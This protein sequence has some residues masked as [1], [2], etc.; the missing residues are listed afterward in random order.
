MGA[1]LFGTDGVRGKADI[2][3]MTAEFALRL[4]TAA[5]QLVCNKERRVAIG[6]DT[7][8]SGEML[9]AAMIAGFTSAGIDVICLGVLPTPA[10]TTLTPDLKV[11]M[12]VMITASH[13]PWHDNGIKLIA[14]DGSKFSDKV[15]SELEALIANGEFALSPEK[16]GRVSSEEML[17][18]KYIVQAMSAV[19][20]G[21]PLKGLRVVL[22]CANGVF[23]E[24]MP[25]V[26]M[27][28]GAGVI[29]IGNKPDGWNINR[30]CGSQHV[31]KMVEAVCGAHAQ[32]GIAV[33]GDGDRIII[34]DEKG[35][36]LDGDQVIAFLGQYLKGKSRLKGNA[37]VATI[38]SNP[39]LDRFLKSQGVDCVRS[40]VGERYVIEEMKRHGANVGGE[41]SGHM[42]LSDYAR[43]GD[44]M[45]AA[46]VVSQGLLESGKKMSE[47][48]PL[49]V[50]MYKKRVDT[51]FAGRE[52]MLAAFELPAF[53]TA[54]AEGERK[55]EGKG[56]V[57]VRTSGTEPKI[58]VWVW[59]DDA[60]L[61]DKVNGEISA[62]L[63]KAPGYESV[64]VMP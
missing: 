64:K 48:F 31:E 62:V 13:N 52:E 39:A 32:L 2:Y 29:A 9:E 1:K 24:I 41:E 8:L 6:R 58:Q 51:R 25:K 44:A 40:G 46:L 27:E 12:S 45:I 15:T 61:A 50:P 11:D 26:F 21:K 33:D 53:K 19:P 16:I 56:R 10:V 34:C 30:E 38:V 22:D 54:I 60:A 35:V 28:L 5:G 63:A 17:V 42:V 18:N 23:S 4:A 57:L 43:T 3:P 7:R 37:V 20:D 47:I 49:F 14:S 59:G 55:I 36:R